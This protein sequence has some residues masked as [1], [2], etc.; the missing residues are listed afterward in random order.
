VDPQASPAPQ[1]ASSM[2]AATTSQVSR[3]I[4]NP[5]GLIKPG[6]Q[7][8]KLSWKTLT[9]ALLFAVGVIALAVVIG[10]TFGVALRG[11]AASLG[12]VAVFVLGA[13]AVILALMSYP[14]YLLAVLKGARGERIG[15][16]SAFA[17]ARPYL[18]RLLGLAI[19]QGLVALAG[20]VLFIIPGFIFTA[21]FST[22]PFVMLEENLGIIDAMKRSKQLVHGHMW[23]MLALMSIQQS[24]T[25]LGLIPLVG[26]IASLLLTLAYIGAPA[27]R[28][29]QLK[30][31]EGQPSSLH[32]VNYVFTLLLPVLLVGGVV[33]ALGSYTS[34]GPDTPQY[35]QPTGG[36]YDTTY[37]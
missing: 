3:Y 30:E 31:V 1:P 35:D 25:L 32:W 22:A 18:I 13:A 28:Y 23:E 17:Q 8:F 10:I 12:V 29:V 37:P 14:V 11:T 4:S 7:V 26:S 21:W 24:F 15:F 34:S 27:V 33:L 16:K 20:F 19:L 9:L 5:L 6:W 36:S 2:P